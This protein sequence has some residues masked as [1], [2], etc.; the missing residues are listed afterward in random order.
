MH[1]ARSGRRLGSPLPPA[2]P[3]GHR[4]P[5]PAGAVRGWP[6]RRSWR[7]STG[8]TSVRCPLN[9]WF[10]R[11]RVNAEVFAPEYHE[12]ARGCAIWGWSVPVVNLWFPRRVA[13][14]IL[15]AAPRRPS[16]P[17]TERRCARASLVVRPAPQGPVLQ[18]G[19]LGEIPKREWRS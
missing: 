14:D 8:R 13:I 19:R 5:R 17:D 18:R 9:V 16:G 3:V 10:H 4:E 6:G 11:A 12:K 1:A 7:R 2:V 15:A